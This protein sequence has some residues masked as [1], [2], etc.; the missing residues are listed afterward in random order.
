M[1]ASSGPPTN[2]DQLLSGA[3][4]RLRRS[5]SLPTGDTL[6][7]NSEYEADATTPPLP[8]GR[9][10]ASA[11]LSHCWAA[12]VAILKPH[13]PAGQA[14]TRREAP[15]S[16][17]GR[18]SRDQPPRQV[19]AAHSRIQRTY[20][21]MRALGRPASPPQPAAWARGPI[22][23]SLASAPVLR[24]LVS[25]CAPRSAAKRSLIVSRSPL[26]LTDL[27]LRARSITRPGCVCA[28]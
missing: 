25:P 5:A 7:D 2:R 15:Q 14:Y 3:P 6:H 21:E 11:A 20:P 23:G 17:F 18:L 28:H 13:A 4:A 9:L 24:Q 22:S 10:E 8:H 27:V 19:S 12:P 26:T 1:T 16:L